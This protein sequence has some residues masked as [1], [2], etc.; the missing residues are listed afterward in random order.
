M[1]MACLNVCQLPR[2]YTKKNIDF[3]QLIKEISLTKLKNNKVVAIVSTL[4]LNTDRD[5]E[6]F[7]I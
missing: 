6:L 7:S 4:Q 3:H 2:T 5:P 1:F